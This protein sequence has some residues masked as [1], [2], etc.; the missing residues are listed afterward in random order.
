MELQVKV[1]KC[2]YVL[3]KGDL[4]SHLFMIYFSNDWCQHQYRIIANVFFAL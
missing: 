1:C 2:I 4:F 3:Y